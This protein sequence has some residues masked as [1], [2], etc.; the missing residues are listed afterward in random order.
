M[1]CVFLDE[2]HGLPSQDLGVADGTGQRR[3]YERQCAWVKGVEQ[4]VWVY[5]T[6]TVVAALLVVVLLK[7]RQHQ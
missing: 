1:A 4:M 5:I 3:R 6:V 2:A 7:R